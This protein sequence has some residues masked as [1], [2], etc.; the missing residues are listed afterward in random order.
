MEWI[1][2]MEPILR[3]DAASG[4]QWVHQVKWDGIR[5]LCRVE[6]GKYRIFTRNRRDRTEFYPELE[7]ITGLLGVK[8]AWLDGEIVVFDQ[9]QKP[10]FYHALVRERLKN[11][12]RA[13]HYSRRN[14]ARYIVFDIMNLDG[15]DLRPLPLRQRKAILEERLAPGRN[16]AVTQ[17]FSD[18]DAL[19]AIMKQKGWEG[20]VS[21]QANSPYTG[22]K[23]HRYWYKTKLQRRILSVVCG[24]FMKGGIPASLILGIRPKEEWVCIGRASLGLTQDH[25]RLLMENMGFLAADSPPFPS[26]AATKDI[27]WFRPILTCWVS[28][29]EWTNDGSLRHPRILGFSTSSPDEADGTEYVE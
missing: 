27:L 11:P 15:K 17:D 4:H 12:E 8:S 24:I 26:V 10:S 21:K 16:V 7:E 18:G 6:N 13:C 14:P 3:P 9:N 28:F 22:G 5:I 19:L 2:P 29:L 20:I 25:F 23:R 1:E